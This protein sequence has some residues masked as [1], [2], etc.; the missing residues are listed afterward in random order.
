ME[1]NRTHL[2]E[3]AALEGTYVPASVS[4]DQ[5]QP[6]SFEVSY[7]VVDAAPVEVSFRSFNLGFKA[8]AGIA[9]TKL[10]IGIVGNAR[11]Q[12]RWFGRSVDAESVAASR[13]TI[14]LSTEG[15]GAFYQAT[16]DIV[17][18]AEK[19]S[20]VPD[21][22]SLLGSFGDL[23]LAR[24]PDSAVRL[25]TCLHQLFVMSRKADGTEMPYGLPLRVVAGTLIPLLAATAESFDRNILAPTGNHSRRLL[26]VRRCEEFMR[27][28]LDGPLTLLDLSRVSS[29]RSRSLINAFKAVTGFSP[30]D[31]L[32]RL[33]LSGV[34]RALQAANKSHARIIDLATGW[35]FW[36]M[37]HFTTEYRAMFGRTPSETLRNK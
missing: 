9:P 12:A 37:G 36:H 29:M 35:G 17:E 34:H 28:N 21:A 3:R 33:R 13:R 4:W 6:G 22:V 7:G 26:A 16:V 30:M 32:K 2:L 23:A 31:Y 27:E 19:F 1:T 5:L 8:E 24:D 14:N 11:T 25:R 10:L 18:L 20:D 15:P